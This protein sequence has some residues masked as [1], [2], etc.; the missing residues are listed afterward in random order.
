[1]LGHVPAGRGGARWSVPWMVPPASAR[2]RMP[3]PATPSVDPL[4]IIVLGSLWPARWQIQNP[5]AYAPLSRNS[6]LAPG[7]RPRSSNDNVPMAA[8]EGSGTSNVPDSRTAPRPTVGQPAGVAAVVGSVDDGE[9]VG[10]RGST[11]SGVDR[12]ADDGTGETIGDAEGATGDAGATT[13][14]GLATAGDATGVGMAGV[15]PQAASTTA[16]RME[17]A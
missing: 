15:L 12:D 10:L 16:R 3:D 1:L 4:P 17:A 9:G 8:R 2:S 6:T 5:T 11:V 7:V 14:L 13:W